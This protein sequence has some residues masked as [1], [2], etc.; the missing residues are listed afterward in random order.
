MELA[1]EV[2]AIG[3]K[4]TQFKVGDPVFAFP[5]IGLGSHAEYRLMP[6]NGRVLP[7]PTGLTREEAAALSFGGT[8]ALHF[9]REQAKLQSGERILIVGASG[10]VGSAAVQLAR[11]FGAEVTAVTS[12][13]NAAMVRALGA[14][15]VIDYTAGPYLDGS[16]TYDVVLDAVGTD[17]Y[18][19]Y[20]GS[21]AKGG[22]LLLAVASLPQMFE[23]IRY[24]KK[25]GHRCAAGG[26]V[27]RLEYMRTLA[28]LA[29]AGAYKPLIDRSFPLQDIAAAHEY[30]DSGRKRGSVL[31]VIP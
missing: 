28:E 8:T 3:S 5:G 4:V 6:E 19:Q 24:A 22:R 7:I 13:A 29:E 10:T 21:L 25:N 15:R 31:V 30:V 11:H 1:G 16:R 20:R 2:V 17:G 18:Q 23:G 26:S 9:L 14:A 27:E 12:A